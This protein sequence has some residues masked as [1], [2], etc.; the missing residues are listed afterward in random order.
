MSDAPKRRWFRYSLRTLA[1]V[2]AIFACW[3]GWNANQVRER[4]E[5]IVRVRMQGGRVDIP[6]RPYVGDYDPPFVWQLMGAQRVS[7]VLIPAAYFNEHHYN[8]IRR[9]LPE[10]EIYSIH[11]DGRIQSHPRFLAGN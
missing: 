3:L 11:S 5:M 4:R 2:I 8:R 6:M 1:I 7:S 9:L 10:A